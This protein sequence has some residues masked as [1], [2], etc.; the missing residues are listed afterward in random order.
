MCALL[1]CLLLL[2]TSLHYQTKVVRDVIQGRIFLYFEVSAA[3][4]APSWLCEAF[5]NEILRRF[6]NFLD[7]REIF[8]LAAWECM[9]I[10]LQISTDLVKLLLMSEVH[11]SDSILKVIHMIYRRNS[12]LCSIILSSLIIIK[13]ELLSQFSSP[14][15]C[16]LKRCISQSLIPDEKA[17]K[18]KWRQNHR[19]LNAL[20]DVIV[21]LTPAALAELK[22]PWQ[23]ARELENC[24]WSAKK[25]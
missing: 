2:P 10:Y 20:K 24:P 17:K 1:I 16:S 7:S 19:T 8:G 13:G 11:C 25:F 3:A 9:Y 14:A 18:E 21:N 15:P 22:F 6:R 23:I 5:L 4:V 12:D